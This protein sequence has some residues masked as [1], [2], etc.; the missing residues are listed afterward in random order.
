MAHSQETKDK[1]RNT[2]RGKKKTPEHAEA[3]RRSK[4]GELN[5]NWGKPRSDDTKAKIRDGNVGKKRRPMTETEKAHQ[6]E[7][8]S[9]LWEKRK[10]G[11]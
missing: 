1:I 3:I 11:E 8:M 4:T 5:P 7:R 10:N 9:R 6:S 2:L